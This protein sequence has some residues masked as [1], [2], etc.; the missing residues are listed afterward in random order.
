[1][2]L[3]STRCTCGIDFTKPF[4][5]K[6]LWVRIPTQGVASLALGWDMNPLR[7]T[8]M[9]ATYML[10]ADKFLPGTGREKLGELK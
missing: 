10:I 5:G 9:K 4:Q 7:G 3:N 2:E 8:R 6:D 1:M